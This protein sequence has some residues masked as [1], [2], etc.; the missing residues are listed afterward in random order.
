[1]EEATRQIM[2]R[3]EDNNKIGMKEIPVE[4]ESV[5]WFQLDRERLQQHFL[6]NILMNIS[7][8]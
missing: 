8:A 5:C 4:Y 6:L 2:R 7:V 3:W 1:M